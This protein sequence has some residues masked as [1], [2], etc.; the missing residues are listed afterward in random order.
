MTD[1]AALPAVDAL[2]KAAHQVATAIPA[3]T[4][5]SAPASPSCSPAGG[6]S[7]P[8][9]WA[10]A[11]PAR[12]SSP[13]ARPH[14]TA[15]CSSSARRR[16][17]ST[18][19]ARSSLVEPD[20]D[21]HVVDGGAKRRRLV[22]RW[23]VVNYDLLGKRGA[24]WIRQSA[25]GGRHRRRGALH[26]E[27]L[28]AHPRTSSAARARRRATPV[29]G[30]DAV[31]LLTGT[32]M[33]NRPRDLFNL[34]K[35]VRHPLANSFY[36]YAKRYCA[37]S[38]NGFGLD[39]NGASNLEELAEIVSGVMLRRTK[40]EALDLP[41]KVRTWLPVDD[42]RHAGRHARGARARLPATATRPAAARPGSRSSGCSTGPPR[43]RRRQGAR[44]RSTPSATASRPARRS[45]CSPRTPPSSRRVK[46]SLRRHRASPSPGSDSA[47]ARQQAADALQTDARVRVLVGNLHAAGV[48]HH[49]HRRDPRRV[50]RPRL[51]AGQP[52][53][54]RG[55]DLPHRPDAPRVRH[56]PVAPDTLDDFVA[57]LLEAKAR[58]IGMLET[59][60]AEHASVLQDAVEAMLRGERPSEIGVR[61]DP[62]APKL[63]GRSACWTRRLTCSL[64]RAAGSAASRAR[65]KR[66]R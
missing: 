42:R 46:A 27:R 23:T 44:H 54:G 5:T 14:P 26:Q 34:L 24:A 16:S 40:D 41:P 62:A 8:T 51:G 35:A 25:L 9:T 45:S 18:G 17:S 56:L 64:G 38:D 49:P 12:R 33:T 11:R 4:P 10:S 63:S 6:R 39:T 15:V 59:D 13:R 2:A 19:A 52:L 28:P 3:C 53:A 48:G 37:P 43:A 29:A 1:L 36:S 58:N 47:V 57:A 30:P 20:A 65:R 21:V 60:A 55:P 50:Q 22:G 32:P 31:Y 61:S 66:S 7:W